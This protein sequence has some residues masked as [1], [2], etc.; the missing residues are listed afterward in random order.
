MFHRISSSASKL[1]STEDEE[2]LL[3]RYK[4]AAKFAADAL[5]VAKAAPPGKVYYT[6]DPEG[7][8]ILDCYRKYPCVLDPMNAMVSVADYV[9]RKF[10]YNS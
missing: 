5:A 8:A 3:S 10:E 6:D 9:V 1:N 2:Q 7:D 4:A